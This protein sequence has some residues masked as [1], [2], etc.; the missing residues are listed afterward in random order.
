MNFGYMTRRTK[1][2][3]NNQIKSNALVYQRVEQL[4]R[5]GGAPLTRQQIYENASVKEVT[6]KEHTIGDVIKQ[7]RNKGWIR[8][9]PYAGVGKAQYAYEWIANTERVSNPV[10]PVVQVENKLPVGRKLHAKEIPEITVTDRK[11]VIVTSKIK[12]TV[13]L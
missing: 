1:M 11:V 6:A 10:S 4:L 12:I 13:E 2:E 9:V 7:F 8:R 5:E 3:L